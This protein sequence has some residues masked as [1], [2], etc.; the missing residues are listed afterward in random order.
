MMMKWPIF[1]KIIKIKQYWFEIKIA[2][3]KQFGGLE[4]KAFVM[5]CYFLLTE[6]FTRK[7]SYMVGSL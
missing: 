4:L 7:P 3:K 2:K 6:F 1:K 5:I